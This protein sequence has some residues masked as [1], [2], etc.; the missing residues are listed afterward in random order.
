[1]IDAFS[2]DKIW[3]P[4]NFMELGGLDDDRVSLGGCENV[5]VSQ[6][7]MK[8]ITDPDPEWL[9]AHWLAQ[10]A[11][12]RRD[13]ATFHHVAPEQVFLTAGAI[14]GIRYAFEVFTKPGTHVGYGRP[15]W[16]GFRHY[17]EKSRT[18]ISELAKPDFPFPF[19]PRDL[20]DF[21]RRE[22]VEFVILSNPS[23][24]TGYLW[25]PDEVAEVLASCPDTVFVID[26]ADAIYPDLSAAHLAGEHTNGVYLGS[27]SKFYGLSGLRIGYMVVPS[28]NVDD[29]DKMVNPAELASVAIVA[30]RES[31]A[32]TAFHEETQRT[33]QKNLANLTAAVADSPWQL[34]EGSRCFAAYLWADESLEDPVSYLARQRI[35]LIGGPIF[36]LERGGRLNLAG[37]GAVDALIAALPR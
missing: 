6:R 33:V 12:L 14:G 36:G 20:I 11:V 29:L 21:V 15:E 32:D 34:V 3:V 10:D 26:E 16:P 8:A 35:D 4:T 37:P 31:F 1:M 23:A 24:V 17:A 25:E 9:R 27:F 18:R 7:A 13:L 28:A 30:A 19:Q 22:G 2:V 5:T